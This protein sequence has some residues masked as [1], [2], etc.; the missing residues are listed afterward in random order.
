MMTKLRSK[1]FSFILTILAAISF[2]AVPASALTYSSSSVKSSWTNSSYTYYS[3]NI[4]NNDVQIQGGISY[5]QAIS[6]IKAGQSVM[7]YSKST[8][9]NIAYAAGGNKTPVGPEIHGSL[10]NG[11][12]YHYHV[13]NRATHAHIWYYSQS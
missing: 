1:V 13:Y 8:A 2:M 6:R 12:Y 3:A 7:C 4:V 9:R 11:Y 5:S 10:N